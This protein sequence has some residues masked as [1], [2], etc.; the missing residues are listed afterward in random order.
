M[1]P[2]C[3]EY[4][5][6]IQQNVMLLW[7]LKGIC[8]D[9]CNDADRPSGPLTKAEAS[10]WCRLKVDN[11]KMFVFPISVLYNMW[12][13]WTSFDVAKDDSLP[14]ADRYHRGLMVTP[15]P[16]TARIQV[17]VLAAAASVLL[18]A[19]RERSISLHSQCL[20]VFLKFRDFFHN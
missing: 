16:L 2:H 7:W 4:S 11:A 19:T 8:D 5:K 6:S 14:L 10:K 17:R 12:K 9:Y 18:H 3:K 15:S 20:M 1:S 13:S